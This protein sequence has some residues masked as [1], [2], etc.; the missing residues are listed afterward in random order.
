MI[1]VTSLFKW[2]HEPWPFTHFKVKFVAAQGT[3]ILRICLS[4]MGTSKAKCC[5]EITLSIFHL[6]FCHTF[7]CLTLLLKVLHAFL[8]ALVYYLS[9][10]LDKKLSDV[11]VKL[12][13][14]NSSTTEKEWWEVQEY[15]C[16]TST[17]PKPCSEQIK[18][19]LVPDVTLLTFNDRVAPAGLFSKLTGYGY[20]VLKRG[21]LKIYW[22]WVG[23]LK[24]YLLKQRSA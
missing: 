7:V 4:F 18:P 8:G 15:V 21:C 9:L 20:V 6:S 14:D 22:V 2:H 12:K 3:T 5:L 11:L 19:Q 1:L 13:R 10:S 24:M 17:E 23:H 16:G